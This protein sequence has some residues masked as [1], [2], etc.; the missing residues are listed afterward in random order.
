MTLDNLTPTCRRAV[1][2]LYG[3]AALLQEKNAKYGDSAANPLRLFSKSDSVEQIRVRID[4]KL[5][6]IRTLGDD[7]REDEDTVR[8]LVGYLALLVAAKTAPS[9]LGVA[10]VTRETLD[11]A[12]RRP[13]PAVTEYGAKVDAVADWE[14]PGTQ[15]LAFPVKSPQGSVEQVA[16]GSIPVFRYRNGEKT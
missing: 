7:A 9:T 8:D 13:L 4:D 11:A 1:D 2:F 16:N 10:S 3:V 15:S 5:S 14:S 12:T 6:R